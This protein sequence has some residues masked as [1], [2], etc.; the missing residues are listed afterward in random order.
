MQTYSEKMEQL[1][2][3]ARIERMLQP[4]V[5]NS[6]PLTEDRFQR[7]LET[8]PENQALFKENGCDLWMIQQFYYFVVGSP[9]EAQLLPSDDIKRSTQKKEDI[10][11]PSAEPPADI[12]SG[13][14]A[15]G[16]KT[17]EN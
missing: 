6:H 1:H 8:L 11:P 17:K 12:S 16:S 7:S 14:M 2:Y 3:G 15:A 13:N 9:N 5:L 10:T 4:Q